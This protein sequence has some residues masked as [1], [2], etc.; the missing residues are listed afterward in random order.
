MVWLIEHAWVWMWT[1]IPIFAPPLTSR[2]MYPL[3]GHDLKKTVYTHDHTRMYMKCPL[4]ASHVKSKHQAFLWK[5]RQIPPGHSVVTPGTIRAVGDRSEEPGTSGI[6]EVQ[7]IPGLVLF[8]SIPFCFHRSRLNEKTDSKTVLIPSADLSQW[9]IDKS[10]SPEEKHYEGKTVLQAA[11][12]YGAHN[13]PKKLTTLTLSSAGDWASWG[14]CLYLTVLAILYNRDRSSCT[15]TIS[16]YWEI[17]S[18]Q[19]W[20]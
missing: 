9:K 3:S 17:K 8:P 11:A 18:I 7:I 4:D 13:P 15:A 2:G 20:W 14:K 12:I 5:T 6:R 1:W 16:H 19:N 10:L